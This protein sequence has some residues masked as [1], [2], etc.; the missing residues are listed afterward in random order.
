MFGALRLGRS[1]PEDVTRKGYDDS[2]ITQVIGGAPPLVWR[3][4]PL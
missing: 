3:G 2:Q 4:V 1:G